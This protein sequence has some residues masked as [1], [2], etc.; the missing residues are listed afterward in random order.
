MSANH[1]I[2][3]IFDVYH[4]YHLPQFD[5]VIEL[6]KNDNRFEVI[7]STSCEVNPE[8]K[9]LTEKI[10]FKKNVQVISE[11]N[12]EKRAKTI[13]GIEPD[14]FI[15]GWSRY[16]LA[17]FVTDKTLVGMIYHG[18]G[19]KPSYWR[20]NHSRLDIRFVE[21]PYRIKQLKD[22]GIK[23]DLVLTGFTKID[24]LIHNSEKDKSS[25]A[26]LTMNNN[27]KTILFAPTF[28]PSSLE[29][30]G[31]TFGESTSDYNVILKPHLWTFFLD[32]F[33]EFNLKRQR[34]FVYNLSEKFEHIHLI[35]PIDY[36]IVPYYKIADLLLTE[37]SSTIYEMIA[38][39]KPIIVNRFF[40]LKLSHRLFQYR[41]FRRRL[42]KEM[43]D[44]ISDFC[45]ELFEPN[46]L[47]NVIHEAFEKNDQ[48]QSIRE[49][50]QHDM[51]YKLDGKASERVRDAIFKK[52]N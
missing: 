48:F 38:L 12:E 43:S 44:A 1:P 30:F 16:P 7:L 4:L 45:F 50:Y 2:K 34:K 9:S 31:Y 33:S 26:K 49:K 17:Q 25:N 37:A 40:K 24:P 22:N 15:C 27:K 36:N 23:T 35:E 29:K 6:L 41:L 21:G 20:D 39:N 10:L 28:Y 18:I 5:P 47:S 46:N 52:L 14:V 11:D 13:R 3:I 51:L 42:N 19:V 8:E 32:S